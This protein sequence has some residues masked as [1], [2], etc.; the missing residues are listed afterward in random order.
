MIDL[1]AHIIHANIKY[2]TN[3][4]P[5]CNIDGWLLL[6]LCLFYN[7]SYSM[8]QQQCCTTTNY[9]EV[10]RC[11]YSELA[12][13]VQPQTRRIIIRKERLFIPVRILLVVYSTYSY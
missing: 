2:P 7:L 11:S 1:V 4:T 8:L 12:V 9:D 13:V 3:I 5:A 6:L 10:Y